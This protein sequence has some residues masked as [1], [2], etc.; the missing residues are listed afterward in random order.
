MLSNFSQE[1]NLPQQD[2]KLFRYIAF[3]LTA[4]SD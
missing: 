4:H 3:E 1:T 2:N